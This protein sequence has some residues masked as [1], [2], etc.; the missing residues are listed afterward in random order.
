MKH[1]FLWRLGCGLLTFALVLGL[2]ACANKPESGASGSFK[3]DLPTK[4]DASLAESNETEEPASSAKPARPGKQQPSAKPDETQYNGSLITDAYADSGDAETEWGE[5]YHYEVR[6]PEL[7]CDSADAKALNAEIMEL[8]GEDAM[9]AP[10]SDTIKYSISWQSHWD[11]SLLSLELT[12]GQPDGEIYH[13]IYYFDFETQTHLTA[14]DVLARMGLSW[15][16][17]EPALVRTAAREHDRVMQAQAVEFTNDL[18]ADTLALRAQSILAAQDAALPLYPNGDGTLTVYLHLAT[19]AG[20]GWMQKAC[21]VDPNETAIPLSA[22]YEFVTAAVDADGAVTVTYH[23]NGD[24]FSGVDYQSIYGF[25]FD[26]PYTIRGC[27]GSY[28]DLFIGNIGSSFE[29]YLFLRTEAGT[30]EYVDL[31]R[32]ARYETYVCA[33][34]LYGIS[35]ATALSAGIEEKTDYS[36][37]TVYAQDSSGKT[38]DLLENVYLSDGLPYEMQAD[39]GCE[40]D[41]GAWCSLSLDAMDGIYAQSG[42]DYYTGFPL[43]LGMNEDELIYALDFW[44]EAGGETLSICVLLPGNGMLVLT[45]L[46]GGIPFGLVPGETLYLAETYG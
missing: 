32:C 7:L 28:T 11:G 37:A 35:G 5:S 4:S 12:A 22:S 45:Q 6:I 8:Y 9:R 43:R 36:Y 18:I 25:A 42:E 26:T 20:A 10:D 1:Q 24:E 39:F 41:S 15:Q 31:F 17:L 34:P 21:A 14:E 40:N 29:P 27:F 33:G 46:A 23:E 2:T 19:Y 38:H 44:D 13:D 16:T 30:L 3:G